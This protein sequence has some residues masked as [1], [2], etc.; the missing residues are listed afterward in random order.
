MRGALM[1]LEARDKRALILGS[2][3]VLVLLAYLLWP[4]G[5]GESSVELVAADQRQG[6][7][8]P[9]PATVQPVPMV[10]AAPPVAPPAVVPEGLS[11]TGVAGSG[12][13]FSFKDGSQRFIGRGRDVAPGVVLQ[14][15]RLRDVI[16]ASGT[17]TY[18]LALGGTA[19]AIQPPAQPVPVGGGTASTQLVVPGAPQNALGGPLITEAQQ[20][21]MGQQFVA[22]LEPRQRGSQVTGWAIRPGTDLLPFSQ[23]GL[24]PGDVLIAVN[25]EAVMDREQVAGLARQIANGSRVQFEFERGG[26]RMQRALEVNPRR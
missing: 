16:L 21:R 3:A 24:Q 2:I 17:M 1:R 20:E 14:A 13:I 12:A 7:A 23:A 18:R 25:G 26:Q 10:A 4:R 22:A 15:V 11:L 5:A 19:V 6:A 8:A 9:A